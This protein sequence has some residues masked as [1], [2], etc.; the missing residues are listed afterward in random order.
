MKLKRILDGKMVSSL[1]YEDLKLKYEKLVKLKGRKA[2]IAFI[3][4]GNN[5]ASKIYLKNKSKKCDELN[6]YQETY[7]LDENISEKELIDKIEILNKKD[8]IDGILLQLPLP[9]GM[10]YKNIM[11]KIDARKDVD[12]FNIENIGSLVL[13]DD[14]IYPCTPQGIM[15]LLTYYNIE[16][17]SKDVL[18]IGRSNIVGKPMA[19]MMINKGA[20]VQVCNSN[21]INLSDKIKRADIVISATG[22]VN[23]VKAKDIKDGA[24]I[25]D[26]GINKKDNKICG[27]VDFDDV[28][29][30]SKAAYISPVPGGVGPMTIYSLIKNT[31]KAFALSKEEIK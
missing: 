18:I 3:L 15:D 25:I 30:N 13:D 6:I 2:G 24:I 20:T 1:L 19:L 4:V 28:Y 26:V 29:N 12:G 9:K 16:V 5:E 7:Y 17:K 8:N 10:D 31:I 21:T 27:D 22:K 11:N 14:G 23:L